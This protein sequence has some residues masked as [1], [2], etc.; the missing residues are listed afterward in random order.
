MKGGNF[1]I[2]SLAL[3]VPQL[4][5]VR[6]LHL[7]WTYADET[8][9]V[10]RFLQLDSTFPQLKSL[11]IEC[12]LDSCAKCRLPGGALLQST[13]EELERK[14]A[15]LIAEKTKAYFGRMPTVDNIALTID[16][17]DIEGPSSLLVEYRRQSP[18]PQ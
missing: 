6:W 13:E 5:S 9:S 11:C 10:L 7:W 17:Y 3:L 14:C 15:R 18:L 8:H 2:L 12:Y 4:P 16:G 1:N